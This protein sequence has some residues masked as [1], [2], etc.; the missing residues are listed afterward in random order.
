MAP[1]TARGALEFDNDV[2]AAIDQRQVRIAYQPI[3]RT[4]DHRIVAAEAL[5][6]FRSPHGGDVPP[7]APLPK[8]PVARAVWKPAPSLATSA[9]SWLTAGGPHHTALST[10][11][12]IEALEDL[13][14]IAGIELVR[15]DAS[16]TTR[17]FRQ[18]LAWSQAYYRLAHGL[19]RG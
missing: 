10:A 15:I 16:T 13:A 5:A 1:S 17:S 19:A 7:D 14:V 2:R 18:E 3:V 8:L 11:V 9:E 4:D 6:R 12:D